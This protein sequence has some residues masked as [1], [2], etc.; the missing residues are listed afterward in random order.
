MKKLIAILT[1]LPCA[2][3]FGSARDPSNY[4]YRVSPANARL[5]VEP[6][7]FAPKPAYPAEARRRHLVGKGL[8]DIRVG[9]DGRAKS[10]DILRST[11]QSL[12]DQAAVGAFRRWR[13]RPRSLG[14][15]RVPIEY[16][17]NSPVKSGVWGRG[18]DN[19]KELGDGVGIVIQWHV[20]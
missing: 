15:V 19:L 10:V 18:V 16:T 8:F 14:L 7:W 11:G 13:F 17:F 6:V 5:K 2:F 3:A 1:L 9:L 20:Q 12:L 4:F